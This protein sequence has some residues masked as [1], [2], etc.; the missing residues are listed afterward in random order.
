MRF[1]LLI[2][3]LNGDFLMAVSD[4]LDNIW[5]NKQ[6]IFCKAIGIVNLK[7]TLKKTVRPEFIEG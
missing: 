6:A 3:P 5:I 2:K 1:S 7:H 4:F